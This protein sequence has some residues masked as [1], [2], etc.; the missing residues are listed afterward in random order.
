MWGSASLEKRVAHNPRERNE[1]RRLAREEGGREGGREDGRTGGK[2]QQ[3]YLLIEV[4]GVGGEVGLLV[5]LRV[6]AVHLEELDILSYVC[7]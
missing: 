7:V 4:D 5:L 1:D 6:P 3:R 2:A